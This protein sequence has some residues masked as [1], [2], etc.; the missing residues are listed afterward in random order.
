[1]IDTLGETRSIKSMASSLLLSTEAIVPCSKLKPLSFNR[2]LLG[3][4]IS[5][6]FRLTKSAPIES[7]YCQITEK[8]PITIFKEEYEFD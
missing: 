1:M 6:S 3:K 8:T 4:H 5:N 2:A 7:Q